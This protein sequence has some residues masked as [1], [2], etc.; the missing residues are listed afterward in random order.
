[1]LNQGI[2]E[3]KLVSLTHN[4]EVLSANQQTKGILTANAL[5]W[6]E[7]GEQRVLP[8]DDVVGASIAPSQT[9]D[10]MACFVVNAYPKRVLGRFSQKC[11][12]VLQE[13][14]FACPD[15]EVRSRWIRAIHNTLRGVSVDGFQTAAPRRLQ[16]L[17]NPMSGK[18]KARSIFKRVRPLLEKSYLHFTVTETTSAGHAQAIVEKMALEEFDGLVIVGGDGTIHEVINGLM[19]RIDWKAAIKKPI[20]AIPGGTGNGLCK[21]L[22]EI[23]GE[24]YDPISAAFLIAKGKERPLDL[25]RVEQN[26]RR[27]YSFLSLSWG[28]VSDVDISSDR[29]RY[30]GSLKNHIYA[31]MRI[32]SLRTYKGKFSFLPNPGWK[33]LTQVE[34]KPLDR[35]S[36]CS[37][38]LEGAISEPTLPQLNQP[39]FQ[40][41]RW[42]VIEDEF[43]LFWAMNVVWAAHDM[44]ATP[45]AHLS[46]GAMDLLVVRRGIS[47]WQLLSAFL[48]ISNGEHISLSH[49]EYYKVRCFRLEPLTNRG[50]LA[51]DGEQVDYSSV[52]MEVLRGIARV[53][54]I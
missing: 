34:C 18:K 5:I 28:I 51:V 16:I 9:K 43:V 40:D 37:L 44:K 31:L 27:Y 42:Q 8:L 13:Y 2:F 26:G 53:L 46:D 25:A 32:W 11:R 50:I 29:L 3:E 6:Q 23:S 7:N 14:R 38:A 15:T 19:S 54:C 12:R 22:L 36:S 4:T 20:G 21:T 33:P 17:L 24:P 10:Q 39:I 35:C 45:H 1:M 49:V 47:K 48:S 52:Q 41:S 30:L